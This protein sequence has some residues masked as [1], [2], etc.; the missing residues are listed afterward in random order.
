MLICLAQPLLLGPLQ[1]GEEVVEGLP[2]DFWG[3]F[4][5]YLGYELKAEC[6]GRWVVGQCGVGVVVQEKECGRLRAARH[7]PACACQALENAA[8]QHHW[9][10]YHLLGQ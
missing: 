8:M 10:L 1:V 6:G 9:S 2:F 3:G 7:G 5:G 4:V